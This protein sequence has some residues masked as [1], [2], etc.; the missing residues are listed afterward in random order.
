MQSTAAPS[1]VAAV[2][3]PVGALDIC[4]WR[5]SAKRGPIL[6]SAE[7]ERWQKD[8]DMNALPEMVFGASSL[9]FEHVA[10]SARFSFSAFDALQAVGKPERD[11]QVCAAALW[12]QRKNP[13]S[14]KEKLHLNFDWTFS[15]KYRGTVSKLESTPTLE[16]I[17]VEQLK[18]PDP[19]LFF[20]DI[21]LFE[22]ELHD[23]GISLLT[24]KTR[25]MPKYF[26]ALLRFYLRVDGVLVRIADTRVYHE[27]GAAHVLREYR[28][29][30]A[31]EAALTEEQRS[32]LRDPQA[33]SEQ[34]PVVAHEAEKF[35]LKL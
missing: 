5:V 22:D 32:V 18:V 15:T 2:T 1:A 6:T 10:T 3:A 17:N 16:R 27:F 21:V 26:L 30:E 13:E 31:Q 33:L 20:E 35:E 23:N 9:A 8:L 25:V 4:G 12:S 7:V 11:L 24:V 14:V 19:I 29:Q 34:L 28:L